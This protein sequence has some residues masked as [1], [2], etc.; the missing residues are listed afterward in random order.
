MV[1]ERE[2]SALL[3]EPWSAF[4]DYIGVVL[5]RSYCE[6]FLS[7]HARLALSEAE[8][9]NTWRLLEMQ[10]H[11]ALMYT[12]CGWFFDDIANIETVKI[13]EYAARSIQLA[14]EVS[15]A[16]FESQ[17]VSDL[18]EAPGNRVEL[19]DGAKVY[20]ALAKPSITD[21]RKGLGHYGISSLVEQYETEQ[22][23]FSFHF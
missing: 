11:A 4:D 6:E 14:R 9:V 20:E 5:S 21:L 7:K 22:R 13:I 15:G 12:S 2:A 3:K 18:R 19:S 10:R 17:F 1:F 16:E 23:I 8:K